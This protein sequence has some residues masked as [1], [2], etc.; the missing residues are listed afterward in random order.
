MSL[1]W[2]CIAWLVVYWI[3]VVITVVIDLKDGEPFWF[4]GASFVASV[5]STALVFAY[6]YNDLALML[7][8]AAVGLTVATIIWDIYEIKT[9]IRQQDFD[10]LKEDFSQ[11][12]LEYFLLGMTLLLY[13]PAH[14][15]G[16][17]VS[18]R[19]LAGPA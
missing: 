14:I 18:L 11:R 3:G 2:W 19:V 6:W 10:E 16:I 12:T 8:Y 4:V 15:F 1:P 17:L 9:D 5:A 13:G 7:G